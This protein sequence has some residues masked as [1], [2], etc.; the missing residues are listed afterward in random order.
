[1]GGITNSEDVSLS[2]CWEEVRDREA[3]QMLDSPAV[4]GVA[5]GGHD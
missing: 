5:R 4:R 1:M 2:K 3:W